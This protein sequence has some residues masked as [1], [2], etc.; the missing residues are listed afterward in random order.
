MKV[1]K[2]NQVKSFTSVEQIMKTL[3]ELSS[4]I[5]KGGGSEK[6]IDE[7]I[8]SDWEESIDNE[9]EVV[10]DE[11]PQYEPEEVNVYFKN[12]EMVQEDGGEFYFED[13]DTYLE[14]D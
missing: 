1:I 11:D 10:L 4:L 6:K 2:E 7:E 12:G 14:E 3:E 9:L 8:P 13:E 5:I